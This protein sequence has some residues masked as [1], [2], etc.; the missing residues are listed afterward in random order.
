MTDNNYTHI[1]VVL[2]RSGSMASIK[3]DM[4]GAFNSLIEDQRKVEGRATVS[5]VQFDDTVETVYSFLHLS[6]VP[7]LDLQP[8]GL[9]ALLDALGRTIN[10]TGVA[11]RDM[12][13]A[14]RPGK[15]I[16]VVITDGLENRSREFTRD[17]VRRLIERQ[18]SEFSWEFLYLGANQNAIQEGAKYGFL[19]DQS[20]AYAASSHGTQSVVGSTSGLLK[21]YRGATAQGIATAGIGYS[22]EDRQDASE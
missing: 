13:E 2:D 14:T 17:T 18:R 6:E 10:E 16:F 21:S 22:D 11:L 12:P 7:K 8:R 4:D 9:T 15:V 5:L 3:S 19:A 20:I 1:A